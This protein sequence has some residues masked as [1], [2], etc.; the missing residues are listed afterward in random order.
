MVRELVVMVSLWL[1]GAVDAGHGLVRH[2]TGN[3]WRQKDDE[4]RKSITL[5]VCYSIRYKHPT[6]FGALDKDYRMTTWKHCTSL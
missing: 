6:M 2:D 5:D 3:Q 4:W 1:T